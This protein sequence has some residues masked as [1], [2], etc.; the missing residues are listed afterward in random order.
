MR[1]S[2]V[3][4]NTSNDDVNQGDSVFYQINVIP[5]EYPQIAVERE[6]DSL[7]NKVFYFLG[8]VADDHGFTKLQFH[9]QFIKI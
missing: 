4:V 8:D 6:N 5:D 9:Y 1:S 7:S 2:L 3:K